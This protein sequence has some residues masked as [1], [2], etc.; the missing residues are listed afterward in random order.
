ML[1]DFKPQRSISLER[2]H[3]E[4]RKTISDNIKDQSQKPE[5]PE[6]T[7]SKGVGTDKSVSRDK[8]DLQMNKNEE[9]GSQNV[10]KFT[11]DHEN[12][13]DDPTDKETGIANTQISSEIPRKNLEGWMR[14]G[15]R[16][17]ISPDS[18]KFRTKRQAIEQLAKRGGCELQVEALRGRSWLTHRPTGTRVPLNVTANSQWTEV[19]GSFCYSANYNQ[20]EI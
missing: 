13:V 16:G 8:N 10:A 6:R 20:E 3:P 2:G 15:N 14:T 19:V 17:L 11:E 5:V 18:T 9:D 1:A 4:K 12:I 7:E